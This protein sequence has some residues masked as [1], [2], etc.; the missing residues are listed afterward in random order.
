MIS[1]QD[2][3]KE[4][5]DFWNSIQSEFKVEM[6]SAGGYR[7]SD[8][9]GCTVEVF[10][11]YCNRHV[12]NLMFNEIKCREIR[13]EYNRIRSMFDEVKQIQNGWSETQ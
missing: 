13:G 4:S 2:E 12:L 9:D 6:L 5:I 10:Q 7:L 8:E 3:I 1:E 11:V